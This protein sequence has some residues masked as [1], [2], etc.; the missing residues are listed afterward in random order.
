[1]GGVA[2]CIMKLEPQKAFPHLVLIIKGRHAKGK[3]IALLPSVG[4][5]IGQLTF[6][7]FADSF[8]A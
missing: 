3:E 6:S 1:M 4:A 5:G 2:P 8:P 7:D